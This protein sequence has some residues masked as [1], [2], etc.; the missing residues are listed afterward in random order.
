MPS[1]L[2]SPRLGERA[3]RILDD[4][5]NW[6]SHKRTLGEVDVF[7]LDATHELYGHMNVNY[8]RL[9]QLPP[10]D[11]YRQLLDAVARGDYFVST[12]EV[13][14]PSVKVAAQGRERVSVTADVSWT[15]PLDIAEIVWGDGTSTHRNIIPLSNTHEFGHTTFRWTH[16]TPGWKWARVAVWD[17]AG[18]G[19][20]T[21]PVWNDSQAGALAH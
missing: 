2:S 17:S 1:D 6:G 19:A 9:P 18:N 7:Q 10:F 21:N 3:F 5:N 8:V 11:N 4:M 14:L 12:G 16:N 13:L 15:F 20:F